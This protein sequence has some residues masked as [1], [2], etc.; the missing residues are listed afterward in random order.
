MNPRLIPF[1]F[2][3]GLGL[4]PL[5]IAA[6]SSYPLTAG[7]YIREGG[8]SHLELSP[9]HKKRQ[10]F[11]VQTMGSTGNM[12]DLTG[13]MLKGTATIDDPEGGRYCKIRFIATDSGIEVST[14]E[15]ASCWVMC[16][17]NAHYDGL[18][19]KPSETCAH[20]QQA[21]QNF[22]QQFDQ[23][24]YQQA[25]EHLMPLLTECSRT[26]NRID[27]DWIRNDIALTQYHLN[28]FDACLTS[29]KPLISYAAKNTDELHNDI[30]YFMQDAYLG[31][32]KATRTNLKLCTSK[33]PATTR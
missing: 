3:L 17:E 24:H 1:V 5:N 8:W 18:Y 19:L 21:R 9:A 25:L 16:G 22:K 27:L 11:S 15:A 6:E 20:P 4:C 14:N 33:T 28:Q 32:I 2:S 23:G 29:L 12:C 10:R 30:P 7:S 31:I 13:M 26:I